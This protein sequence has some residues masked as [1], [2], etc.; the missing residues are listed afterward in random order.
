MNIYQDLYNEVKDLDTKD[1]ILKFI[2]DKIT[3]KKNDVYSITSSSFNIKTK[4]DVINFDNL[5]ISSDISLNNLFIYILKQNP[6]IFSLFILYNKYGNTVV[7]KHVVNKKEKITVVKLK[8]INNEIITKNMSYTF[9][10]FKASGSITIWCERKKF[11]T[12][13]ISINNI[14]AYIKFGSVGSVTL[15]YSQIQR[16][17]KLEEMMTIFKTLNDE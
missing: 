6:K 2:L 17:I 4:S 15:D 3:V 8:S 12:I 13:Y 16:D 14:S 11:A 10:I 1:E 5:L 9:D 7:G